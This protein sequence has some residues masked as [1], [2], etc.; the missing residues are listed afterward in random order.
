[1]DFGFI[2][3][4]TFRHSFTAKGF[5][6]LLGVVESIAFQELTI[7]IYMQGRVSSSGVLWGHGVGVLVLLS[8]SFIPYGVLPHAQLRQCQLSRTS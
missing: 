2:A 8:L 4:E 3:D 7:Y 6:T 1:M 5:E